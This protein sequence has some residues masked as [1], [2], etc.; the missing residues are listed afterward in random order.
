MLQVTEKEMKEVVQEGEEETGT[1]EKQRR[2][3]D[4]RQQAMPGQRVDPEY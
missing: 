4:R 2:T 1:K 3:E